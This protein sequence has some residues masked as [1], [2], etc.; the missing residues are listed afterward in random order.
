LT[1][2]HLLVRTL[3]QSKVFIVQALAILFISRE[4]FNIYKELPMMVAQYLTTVL[5]K[6]LKHFVNHLPHTQ[7]LSVLDVIVL[8]VY[9]TLPEQRLFVA[10]QQLVVQAHAVLER[11][12]QISVI[13]INLLH[14]LMCLCQNLE[15]Q[16]STVLGHLHVLLFVEMV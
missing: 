11:A 5:V 4:I 15:M 10:A 3:Q 6:Y 2:N 14:V 13:L 9:V 12:A 8:Y 16:R 7:L 1:P